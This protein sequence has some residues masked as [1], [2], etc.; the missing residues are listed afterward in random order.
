M[1]TDHPSTYG[2]RIARGPMGGDA[3]TQVHNDLFRDRRLSAKAMGVFGHCSTHKEGWHV[4]LKSIATNMRDGVDAISTALAELEKHCYLIRYR[5]RNELGQVGDW[6]YFFTDLPA[7]LLEH[8]LPDEIVEARVRRAFDRWIEKNGLSGPGRRNPVQGSTSGNAGEDTGPDA[9]P[10][11]NRGSEEHSRR[12]EPERDLP[13]QA[14]PVQANPGTK[15]TRPPED[16][17]PEDQTGATLAP[18]PQRTTGTTTSSR[19]TKDDQANPVAGTGGSVGDHQTARADLS[20]AP[21]SAAVND[22]GVLLSIAHPRGITQQQAVTRA[23]RMLVDATRGDDFRRAI[24]DV[25]IHARPAISRD[26][27]RHE[28]RD[29]IVLGVLLDA[30]AEADAAIKSRRPGNGSHSSQDATTPPPEGDHSR[31][32]GA[33]DQESVPHADRIKAK[34]GFLTELVE[35]AVAG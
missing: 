13:D 25:L 22:L 23:F 30:A 5:E 18:D 2:A 33:D 21:D 20:V 12:S 6:V 35:F 1:A 14:D 7:Q 10:E 24:E 28:V 31:N 27:A 34:Y 26:Q 3:Y 32:G 11:G 15:K 19:R 8:E 9:G 16:Q 29:R 4:T 17:T